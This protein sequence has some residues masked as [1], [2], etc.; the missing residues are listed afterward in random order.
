MAKRENDFQSKLKKEIESMFPD[1]LIMKNDAN[2]LQGIPDLTV[3]YKDH[4]AF[5]E[6]KRQ[7]KASYQT[8]QDYYIDWAKSQGAFSSFIFPENKKEVLNEL[9]KAFGTK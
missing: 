3:L 8:N 1:C 5:L 7:T 6:C 2:Y 9:R 4:W